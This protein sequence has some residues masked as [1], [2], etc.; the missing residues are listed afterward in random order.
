MLTKIFGS[1]LHG[2]GAFR[3]T[4]EV[5]VGRGLGYFITGQPDEVVREGL[6]RVE[7]AIKGL[8]FQMPRTKLSIN[9]APSGV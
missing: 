8:G 7:V 3:I 6:G 4:I 1:I 9:R 2:V 5:N